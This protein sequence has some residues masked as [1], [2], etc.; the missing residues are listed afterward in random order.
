MI[1][2]ISK[3]M[4]WSVKLPKLNSS[5]SLYLKKKPCII[6]GANLKKSELLIKVNVGYQ[7]IQKKTSN[8]A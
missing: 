2:S 4:I 3:E 7:K 1:S 8:N 5:N 6:I